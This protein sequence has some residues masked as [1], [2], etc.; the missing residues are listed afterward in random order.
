VSVGAYNIVPLTAIVGQFSDWTRRM[1]WF[2]EITQCM[3]RDGCTGAKLIDKLCNSV[4]TGYSD[5]EAVAL[6]LVEVAER[7]WIKQASSW[8]LYGR[9]PSFGGDD[10]FVHQVRGEGAQVCLSYCKARDATS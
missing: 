5:I 10:F 2:W 1:E 9:L 6:H 3:M 7:A 8:I 4:Q